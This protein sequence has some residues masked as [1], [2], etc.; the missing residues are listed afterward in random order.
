MKKKV[1]AKATAVAVT[2]TE[3]S[4]RNSQNSQDSLMSD[5]LPR[6]TR[7]R[8]AK[9]VYDASKKLKTKPTFKTKAPQKKTKTKLKKQSAT[10]TGKKSTTKD[11]KSEIKTV[12]SADASLNLDLNHETF[13]DIGDSTGDDPADLSHS[14]SSCADGS[15]V[16]A[17]E[18]EETRNLEPLEEFEMTHADG[19]S[20]Q[21]V[22]YQTLESFDFLLVNPTAALAFVPFHTCFYFKGRLNVTILS[23]TTEVLGYTMDEDPART[24]KIYSPRGYS[25]TC[26]RSVGKNGDKLHRSVQP[27]LKSHGL[28]CD[29]SMLKQKSTENVL[30]LLQSLNFGM[31]DYLSRLFTINIL[32]REDCL[33]PA[34]EDAERCSQLNQLCARLDTSVILRGAVFNARFYQQPDVWSEYAQQLIDKAEAKKEPVRL[35]LCGRKGV[36][37]STLLRYLANRLIKRFGSVLVIDFDPGQPEFF[38]SGCVSASLVSEP[39]LGPNFTHFQQPLHSYFIGDTDITACPDRYMNSCRRL[40]L[41]CRIRTQLT[42][43]PVL[44]NTMGFT[45]GV[46]LDVMLDLIRLSQPLQVSVDHCVTV[47]HGR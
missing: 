12:S 33:P 43:V 42:P 2:A 27:L 32:R 34:W 31:V 10:R 17:R 41:D 24:Y 18:V 47:G 22:D 39:L 28:D 1:T 6:L 44:L 40:L 30:L 37:K 5:C 29:E 45:V 23:G 9:S 46:G 38:P 19:A 8:S 7:L 3:T 35:M 15:D 25:L 11:V 16:H 14:S 4:A 36:G 13:V 20:K 21:E 26:I